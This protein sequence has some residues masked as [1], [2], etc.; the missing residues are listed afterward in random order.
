MQKFREEGS[1]LKFCRVGGCYITYQKCFEWV[2][3]Y[4]RSR[5]T[6]HTQVLSMS[7]K[8]VIHTHHKYW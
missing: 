6:L 8:K 3:Y 2:R 5:Q 7:N 1:C 4:L